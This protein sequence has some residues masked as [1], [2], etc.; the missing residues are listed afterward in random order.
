MLKDAKDSTALQ[1][2]PFKRAKEIRKKK[3]KKKNK[4]KVRVPKFRS[5][6]IIQRIIKN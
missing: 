6:Y 4:K 3:R 2:G 1:G 5:S